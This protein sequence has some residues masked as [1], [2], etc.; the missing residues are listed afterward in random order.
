MS[1]IIQDI[2]HSYSIDEKLP[3]HFNDNR[4]KETQTFDDL[5]LPKE[6][7]SML[8]AI[9]KKCAFNKLI[10]MIKKLKNLKCGIV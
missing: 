3:A 9:P 6:Y 8:K 4:L 1:A 7:K 10:Q 2:Y 5:K